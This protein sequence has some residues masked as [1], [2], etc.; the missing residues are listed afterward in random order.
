VADKPQKEEATRVPDIDAERLMIETE[1]GGRNPA[2][3]QKILIFLIAVTWSAFQLFASW[4][5]KI[6]PMVLRA[7]HLA[8]AFA[9]SFLA[10]P[11]KNARRDIWL[12]LIGLGYA[13]YYLSPR[14]FNLG[15]F[16]VGAYEG[17]AGADDHRV[18]D[19]RL[20]HDR[21]RRGLQVRAPRRPLPP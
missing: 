15:T 21:T 14:V 6:D 8:F 20:R 1:Y 10:Y 17:G 13:L 2:N 16:T 4:L 3:W 7:V 11:S 5:G 12:F 9:I 19:D 18:V